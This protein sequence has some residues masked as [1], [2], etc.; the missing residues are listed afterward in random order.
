MPEC[1]ICKS[2]ETNVWSTAKDY[3]YHSTENWYTYY[4]C[5]TC[6]TI[7]IDPVPLNELKLIYPDNYYS[8]VTGKKNIVVSIKEWLD[9]RYFKSILKK[10][11]KQKISV[12]D[13]GGGTGWLSSLVRTADERICSTQIVDIDA[14]TKTLAEK[15]GHLYYQGTLEDFESDKR[16]D[17]IL[18]LNLIEHVQNPY[19]IIQKAARLLSK[20]G[21]IL[22][23]TPNT[24][25]LDARVF[26]NSYWGGLHCPRHWVIFSE[27][28]FRLMIKQT[29]LKI[30]SLQYTQGAPFWAFSIIAFLAKIKLLRVNK[31]RPI[32]FHPAFP[33]VSAVAAMFDFVRRPIS[34]TS[35]MFIVLKHSEKPPN[36]IFKLN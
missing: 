24:Q 29:S 8:F 23:K 15:N 34:K 4:A 36:R 5:T 33:V 10:I 6:Q 13:V 20:E 27:I 26:K 31:K 19:D 17:L 22:I 16:F 25:S 21:I 9:K 12:L 11:R 32:I 7:F 30:E 2:H 18:M 28:S 14:G 35:Q 1:I 3:E